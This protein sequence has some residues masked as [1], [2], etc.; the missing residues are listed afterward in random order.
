[1]HPLLLS[2]EQSLV[3][4]TV[5]GNSPDVNWLGLINSDTMTS[6]LSFHSAFCTDSTFT[7]A[8]TTLFFSSLTWVWLLHSAIGPLFAP[9]SIFAWLES[10]LLI[11]RLISSSRDFS[12]LI[13]SINAAAVLYIYT[14]SR[15]AEPSLS[16]FSLTFA[17]K[18]AAAAAYSPS[19][20]YISSSEDDT[21]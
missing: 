8:S 14:S 7:N 6:L 11:D 3:K 13:D 9:S 10:Y 21:P 17:L 2:F 1:M 4:S 5:A 16:S 19:L 12:E 20:F 18:A 15:F